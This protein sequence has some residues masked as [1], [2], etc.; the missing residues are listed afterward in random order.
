MF[1]VTLI[2]CTL[3]PAT[4]GQTE[5]EADYVL[6]NATIHDGTGGEGTIGDV[7]IKDDRV[8]AVGK[9]AFKGNPRILDCTGLVIAPGFIDLHT[10]SD[11]PITQPKTNINLNYLTQGVTTVVTGNCGFGPVDV[12]AYFKKMETGGIGSNVMHQVPH[13]AVRDKVMGNV[14][15]DATDD[16]LHKMEALVDQGM[17]DGAWGFATGLIYNPGTY[18]KTDE[19]IAL[20]KVAAKHGGF[21]ASH[22]RNE[23]D[24]VFAA[25]EEI[26]LIA[27]RAGL[28]V[29]ISHIKVTGRRNW[30]K[31]ADVIG[32]LRKARADGIE[33]TADQYPYIASSTS[34]S[35]MLIPERYREGSNADLVK[36]FDDPQ[37]G[38]RIRAAIEEQLEGRD[39]ARTFRIASY[40]P[41]PA[42]QGK[43]LDTIA[44]EEK[45]SVL[46][47]VLEVQRNG[48]ASAVRFGMDE[49][50]VRL[51]MKEPFVATASDGHATLPSKIA[52]HPRSYG[53]FPRK[54]GRYAL[55]DKVISLGQGVR[56]ASG[57]PADILKLGDRGYVKAGYFADIVVF[58]PKAFRDKAT[59]DQPHQYSTGVVFLFVNGTLAIER[60]NFT[61]KLAGRVLRHK[62]KAN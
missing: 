5:I 46:D 9:F 59:F 56:S 1:S 16:E 4:V 21:Y 11:T 49:A 33:V 28:R 54:I 41:K 15:R 62:S 40:K 25:I 6:R 47:I 19:L 43:D 27:R 35:D 53:T 20:A 12:A 38:P 29:H 22:I 18:C 3:L 45:K 42:W 14:N 61:D 24:R 34:L 32:I 31:A 60:G 52:L 7:A 39:G 30:G 37:L 8:V 44:T 51:F 55:E 26:L 17:R 50:D 10:H 48:G 36:R 13:N 23:D 57:L 2:A 58:D